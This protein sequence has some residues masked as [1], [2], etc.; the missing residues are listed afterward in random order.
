[1]SLGYFKNMLLPIEF[2]LLFILFI[3]AC[4][5]VLLLFI[6][7]IM[8]IIIVFLFVYLETAIFLIVCQIEYLAYM[9][10]IIYA[11]AIIILFIFVLMLVNFKQKKEDMQIL[12]ILDICVYL[13]AVSVS[14]SLLLNWNTNFFIDA[15]PYIELTHLL[16]L[17]MFS[18][19]LNSIYFSDL[20]Q[21]A[22]ILYS[23]QYAHT[24]VLGLTLLLALIYII[25]YL[26]K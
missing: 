25:I 4:Q 21:I 8:H 7:N 14:I 11:G 18:N 13:S 16:N 3:I 5:I 15:T 1:M 17:Y 19:S 26:K 22:L 24:L 20:T 12:K 9:F 10:L 23:D 6:R 2:I